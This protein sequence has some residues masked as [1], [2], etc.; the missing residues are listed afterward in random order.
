MA[1]TYLKILPWNFPY[2][3]EESHKKKVRIVSNLVEFQ[4]K[5]HLIKVWSVTA[6]PRCSSRNYEE[7]V[8]VVGPRNLTFSFN[9]WAWSNF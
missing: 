2:G 4:S 9:V 1:V 8:Y 6:T 3:S 7:V 5:H